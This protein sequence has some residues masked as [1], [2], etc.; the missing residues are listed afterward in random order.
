MSGVGSPRLLCV[1][2]HFSGAN[3]LDVQSIFRQELASGGFTAGDRA[4]E[5]YLVVHRSILNKF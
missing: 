1:W 4:D 3:A 5:G 2:R